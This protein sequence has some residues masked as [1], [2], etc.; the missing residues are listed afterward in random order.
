M[1]SALPELD[2]VN[3][4]ALLRELESWEALTLS[5]LEWN[6]RFLPR[7]FTDEPAGFHHWLSGHLAELHTR[8]GSRTALIAP[9]ES[10]KSTFITLA[11]ALRC[12]LEAHEPYILLLSDSGDQANKFLLDLRAE[13]DGN[14]QLAAVYPAACGPGAGEWREGAVR[15]KNGVLLESLGRGAKIRGRRNRSARPSLVILD[16]VQSNRD[17]ISPTERRRAWDWF[18]REVIPAGTD[19]TNFISVGTALH[20]EAVAVQ[21]RTLP[22]WL[23]RTFPAIIRWPTDRELWA[24]WE[25]LAGNL[26]DDR[27]D[28]TAAAFYAAHKTDMDAGAETYWPSRKPIASLMA[29]RAELGDNAFATEYQGNPAS[30]EGA[31]WPA[32]YFDR[33][34]LWFEQWPTGDASEIL[35]RVQSLDPSKGADSKSGDYQAHILAA[36]SR[37]GHL[38]VE[39]FLQREPIDRMVD[40]ALD[41]PTLTGFGAPDSIAVENNDSLGMVLAE[42]FRRCRE[43]AVVKPIEG[44]RQTLNKVVRIRRLGVYFAQGR[45]RFR[46][47][48][49]TRLLVEQLREFPEGDH[50]D[51]P[52]ALELAIRRIELALT[53]RKDKR[54]G[55]T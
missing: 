39:A 14:E 45:I 25:W 21:C 43:L 53:E 36:V 47:T 9:R 40:R 31:E 22:G 50:D 23:A 41:L 17:I 35:Y 37:N 6:R 32:A 28:Q 30:P 29:K 44:V 7:Y 3:L 27:R 49:G 13:L 12:A 15:L 34:G 1:P 5:P 2:G 24:R 8:R 48:A 55:R 38:Y 54:R 33:P 46:N 10:A 4:P 51:G 42:F 16:D 20:R 18:T 19:R 52:D 11:Y 26:A